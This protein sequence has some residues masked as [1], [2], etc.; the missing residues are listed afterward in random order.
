MSDSEYSPKSFA[1]VEKS[2]SGAMHYPQNP[3]QP[4]QGRMMTQKS[5]FADD[6]DI[7]KVDIEGMEVRWGLMVFLTVF[8]PF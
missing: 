8:E 2:G 1:V 5:H 4:K 6:M 3:M 7:S